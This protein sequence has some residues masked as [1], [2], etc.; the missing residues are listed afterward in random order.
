MDGVIL[1]TFRLFL[2]RI[3][4]SSIGPREGIV[5]Y[6]ET[7]EGK[8]GWAEASPLPG[9]S[10]ETLSQTAKQLL[11]LK[12]P[13]L[14][15]RSVYEKDKIL[16][17][18]SLYPSVDFGLDSLFSILQNESL[19]SPMPLAA[20]LTGS[21]AE[22]Q[23]QIPEIFKK[24]YRHVKLKISSLSNKEAHAVI[25][26]LI[27]KV[28]L[29]IDANQKWSLS[30]ALSFCSKYPHDAFEYI[31]EPL[32]CLEEISQFP[33]PI[34]LD[35]TLRCQSFPPL[36]YACAQVIKPMML[37][38]AKKIAPYAKSKIP[39]ILSSS[40]ESGIGIYHIARLADRLALPK[41]AIGLDTYRFL[42]Q[43]LLLTPHMIDEGYIHASPLHVDLSTLREVADGSSLG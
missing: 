31:E 15:C 23:E 10:Q 26:Q 22:I 35:E 24:K 11:D 32:C 30:E 5:I 9:W 19:P 6:A 28:I 43:D 25:E 29:R 41:M 21:F 40:Y 16:S 20:L 8:S 39:A 2:F 3:E 13:L 18:S 27:G 33:Y 17:Q 12:V 42:H 1:E 7:K 37:G 36:A 4:F 14:Q 38:G 34:A